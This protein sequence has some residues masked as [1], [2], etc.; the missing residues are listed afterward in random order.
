[1]RLGCTTTCPRARIASPVARGNLA[2]IRKAA[3]SSHLQRVIRGLRDF[4]GREGDTGADIVRGDGVLALERFEA[5]PSR[6]GTQ[7]DRDGRPRAA[8][9]RLAMTDLGIN[10]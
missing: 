7:N 2:S 6:E 1:M 8:D 4:F 3:I 5:V 10:G 9:H